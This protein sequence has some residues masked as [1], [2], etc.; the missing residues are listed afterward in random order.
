MMR[1]IMM[2]EVGTMFADYYDKLQLEEETTV[3]KINNFMIT[4]MSIC[5]KKITFCNLPN[6]FML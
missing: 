4:K 2:N 5:H 3:L 1:I 6:Y